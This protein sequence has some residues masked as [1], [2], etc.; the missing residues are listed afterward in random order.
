MS[1]LSE[2]RD[3][4]KR[5]QVEAAQQ[6]VLLEQKQLEAQ[7]ALQKITNTIQSASVKRGEMQD[8]RSTIADEN[9]ALTERYTSV[10]ILCVCT[11][12][13]NFFLCRKEAIDKDLADIEPLLM[14]ARSAVSEIRNEALAEIRSLRAPPEVIRDILVINGNF[15]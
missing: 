13:L 1:K 2:A 11:F 12:D 4:V 7:A 15:H 5:L 10:F 9:L 3:L 8:L 6:E 14:E